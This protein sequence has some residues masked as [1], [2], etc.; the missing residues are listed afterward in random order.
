[1]SN[2]INRSIR[3]MTNEERNRAKE[4]AE[5]NRSDPHDDPHDDWA[6]Y[7]IPSESNDWGEHV[8]KRSVWRKLGRDSERKELGT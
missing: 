8:D 2:S 3:D 4:K 7:D 6:A 1:M 5:A